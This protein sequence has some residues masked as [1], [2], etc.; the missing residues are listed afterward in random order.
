MAAH[1]NRH[2]ICIWFCASSKFNTS[3]NCGA[4]ERLPTAI[5]Y[6]QCEGGKRLG[7]GFFDQEFMFSVYLVLWSPTRHTGTL[8]FRHSD[9]C[10]MITR[11]WVCSHI[12]D[13]LMIVCL[14]QHANVVTVLTCWCQ[15]GTI[16]TLSKSRPFSLCVP[17]TVEQPWYPAEPRPLFPFNVSC[18]LICYVLGSSLLKRKPHVED[19]LKMLQGT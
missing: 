1:N 19:G 3:H 15:A 13:S 12:N 14:H 10:Y 4:C 7:S 11:P 9:L 2:Y 5:I 8:K 18:T 17:I 6:K 16:L